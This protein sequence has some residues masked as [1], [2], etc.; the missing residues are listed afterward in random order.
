VTI[1]RPGQAAQGAKAGGGGDPDF[2]RRLRQWRTA[3][4][5][6]QLELA[7]EAGVS[8]RHVS[9]LETGRSRPSR[10]MVE[11][12]AV[13]LDVPLRSRNELLLAA[14]LAPRHA[15]RP[16]D[17]PDLAPVRRGVEFLLAAH[18]PYPAFVLDHKL[19]VVLANRAHHRFLRWALGRECDEPN[20]LRLVLAPDLLKPQITNWP[21]V[22]AVLVR[23][24]E[25]LIAVPCPP[26]V[27]DLHEEILAY[28]GVRAAATGPPAL[29]PSALLIPIDYQ[30]HGTRLRWFTTLASFG[31]ALDVTLQEIVIELLYPMDAE[32]ARAAARIVGREP[33]SASSVEGT[34]R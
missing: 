7:V 32:T 33:P 16:F 15:A 9:F 17:D 3:R 27:R 18:E 5:L 14:G 29:D 1:E 8:A 4:R 11:R 25:G 24:L 26:A 6:S 20:I 21:V 10:E 28:P 22:A 23:R 31:A 12:L 30:A 2:G 19:D 34:G 13:V